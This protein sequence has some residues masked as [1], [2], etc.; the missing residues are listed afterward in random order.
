MTRATYA[1]M[2]G[3]LAQAMR[4]NAVGVVVLPVALVM[5][6]L[7]ALE[8][9]AGRKFLP[10]LPVRWR[11][12]LSWSIAVLMVGFFVLRNLPWWPFSLLAP[13]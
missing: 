1:L 12:R 13:H 9:V 5:C 7:Y 3:E 10:A 6:F 4:L 8:W 11:K 2:H